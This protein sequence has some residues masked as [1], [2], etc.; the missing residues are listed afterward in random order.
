MFA[1]HVPF[2]DY[3]VDELCGIAELIAKKRGLIL[4]DDAR[5]KINEVFAIALKDS[6]LGNGRYVRNVL[7]K[8]KMAQASRLVKMDYRSVTNESVRNIIASDIEML[9]KKAKKTRIGFCA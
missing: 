1:Y 8:A 5:E 4:A 2:D 9:V 3:N 6:D 7:E